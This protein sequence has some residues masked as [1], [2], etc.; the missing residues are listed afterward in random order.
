VLR[1]TE[2]KSLAAIPMVLKS[3]ASHSMIIVKATGFAWGRR[4]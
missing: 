1:L 2:K 3:S 4:Q